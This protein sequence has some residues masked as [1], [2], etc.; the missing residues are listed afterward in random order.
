MDFVTMINRA[1][2]LSRTTASIDPGCSRPWLLDD[3]MAVVR[4]REISAYRVVE[5]DAERSLAL[6]NTLRQ[7]SLRLVRCRCMQATI[8]PR[9]GISDAHSRNTSPVQSLCWSSSVKA[10][11]AVGN[12]TRHAATPNIA[13]PKFQFLNRSVRIIVPRFTAVRL[14]FAACCFTRCRRRQRS[15]LPPQ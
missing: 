7:P 3:A 5:A 1:A 8:R 2:R 15:S 14:L 13:K 11:P 6:P 4:H 12:A 9:S 10:C